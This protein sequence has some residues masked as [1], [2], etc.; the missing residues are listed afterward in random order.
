M[1]RRTPAILAALAIAATAAIGLAGNASA[2]PYVLP[3]DCTAGGGRV[4]SLPAPHHAE[5]VGGTYNGDWIYP[6]AP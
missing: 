3:G 1:R 5:C 6:P 4:L 2:A